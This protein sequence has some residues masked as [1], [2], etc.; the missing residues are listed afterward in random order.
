MF[1]PTHMTKNSITLMRGQFP[2]LKFWARDAIYDKTATPIATGSMVNGYVLFKVP[3]SREEVN[4][5]D[6]QLIFDDVN[7]RQMVVVVEPDRLNPW[8]VPHF[9]GME[10]IEVPP[11][12]PE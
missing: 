8:E 12:A 7:D 3:F 1:G 10:I 11:D 5:A 6:M 9:P 2:G 4:K